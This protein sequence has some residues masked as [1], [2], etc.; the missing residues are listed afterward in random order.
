MFTWE[1]PTC[2]KELDIAETQ[3]PNCSGEAEASKGSAKQPEASAAPVSERLP[4]PRKAAAAKRQPAAHHWGIQPKHLGVFAVAMVVAVALAVYLARPDAFGGGSVELEEVPAGSEEG[5]LLGAAH[6]GD[7]EV[8]GIRTWYDSDYKPKVRAVVINH[9]EQAKGN[10]N[11][12][13]QLRPRQAD[14]K[15]SPL[16]SF[17]IQ[18]KKELGPRESRDVEA[19]LAALGTLQS[20]PRW[21]E[22]RVDVEIR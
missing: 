4:P 16:A 15:V 18:L 14:R 8:A 11:L 2:G 13:V 1:C 19:D 17:D 5:A 20:L 12:Q 21:D 3:C 6:V 9:G 7:L 22:L 10:V